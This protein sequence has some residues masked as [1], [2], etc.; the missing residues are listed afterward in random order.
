MSQHFFKLHDD[1]YV[2]GRW[3]LNN[4]TD[5][6]GREVDDPWIFRR[7]EPVRLEGRLKIPIEHVGRA[8]DFSL[9]GLSLGKL[10]R[11]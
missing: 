2:T 4:P 5:S 8:L 11:S 1:V 9:A 3:L 6:Q 7:G 10:L